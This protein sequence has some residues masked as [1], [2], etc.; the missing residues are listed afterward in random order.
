M[1]SR[2]PAPGKSNST[3]R[4]SIAE[5]VRGEI[6]RLSFERSLTSRRCV[7]T[8]RTRQTFVRP[9]ASCSGCVGD[10][11]TW[12]ALRMCLTC[13]SVGC[14]DSSV[15]RH[16]AGHFEATGHPLMRSIEPGDS[17]GWCYVDEAYLA[18]DAA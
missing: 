18:P 4:T 9:A 15:G 17:W 11:T 7:H 6:R 14:C 13:G 2:Q 16:A 5:R 12:L 8:G 3:P 10:G 1:T